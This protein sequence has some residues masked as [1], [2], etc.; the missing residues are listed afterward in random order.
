M[1]FS[2][3]PVESLHHINDVSAASSLS[4]RRE[5]HPENV[6]SSQHYPLDSSGVAV[7]SRNNVPDIRSEFDSENHGV[8]GFQMRGRPDHTIHQSIPQPKGTTS[9]HSGINSVSGAALSGV[10]KKKG[11]GTALLSPTATSIQSESIQTDGSLAK[12]LSR[13]HFRKKNGKRRGSARQ[14]PLVD[15]TSIPNEGNR[16]SI[17]SKIKTSASSQ[18]LL[19]S[20]ANRAHSLCVSNAIRDILQRRYR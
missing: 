4:H 2:G 14:S 16:G 12:T 5:I 7:G 9:V 3:T 1:A 17:N 11:H 19:N 13:V 6:V 8:G 10:R 18:L 20:L 15:L